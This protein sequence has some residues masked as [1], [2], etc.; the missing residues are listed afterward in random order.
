MDLDLL[1]I[2]VSTLGIISLSSLQYYIHI[3]YPR[4]K[5]REEKAREK[6][7]AK[8]KEYDVKKKALR[9]KIALCQ[10]L[11]KE[12][13]NYVKNNVKQNEFKFVGFGLLQSGWGQAPTPKLQEKVKLFYKKVEDCENWL[14]AC[15][16]TL[17]LMLIENLQSHLPKSKDSYLEGLFQNIIIEP[18]IRGAKISRSWLEV[19]RPDLIEEIQKKLDP[20]ED[21]NIFFK[22][23]NDD[24]KSEH[25]LNT[26]NE[27][28]EELINFSEEC[29]KLLDSEKQRLEDELKE[30][31]A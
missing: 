2:I 27:K 28:R 15:K 16:R 25:S 4:K 17:K 21:I 20:S 13:G 29:K 30:M 1:A 9:S 24:S 31:H 8:K 14:K 26:L 23:M 3:Y 18:I 7:E 10:S 12:I 22:E 6:A 19:E 11:K 5:E